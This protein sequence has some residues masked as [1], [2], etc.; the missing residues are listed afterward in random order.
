MLID[1]R[2]WLRKFD[3]KM[4]RQKRFIVLTIDNFSGHKIDYEPTNIHAE[5]FEPNF[6]SFVQ[7]CDAG[8]IRCLKAHYRRS[9]ALRALDLYEL[10]HPNPFKIDILS[11]MRFL[12]NAWDEVT[13]STIANCWNHTRICPTEA[14]KLEDAK[15][16]RTGWKVVLAFATTLNMELSKVKERLGNIFGS[17]HIPSDLA[18]A[19]EAV[20]DAEEDLVQAEQAVRALMPDFP[21]SDEEMDIDEDPPSLR[22]TLTAETENLHAGWDIILEFATTKMSLPQAEK[23]LKEIFGTGYVAS[24]WKPAFD[25]VVDAKEDS[26]V[27]EP[28]VR[29]L[30]P[31]FTKNSTAASSLPAPIA[32]DQQLKEA[33]SA[34]ADALQT[35]RKERCLRGEEASIDELLN[36]QI[37]QEDL[38]SEFLAIFGRR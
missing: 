9:L 10:D 28:A 17:G 29:T 38:D 11:A 22:S 1:L 14:D 26:A 31:D 33:E 16:L 2:R 36:L 8:I 18:S 15:N 3:R 24:D 25:A 30:M 32:N 23:R 27:A 35:L 19:L 21:E 7:P 34:F 4:R 5:F 12:T 13:L 6:T 37:E 20:L